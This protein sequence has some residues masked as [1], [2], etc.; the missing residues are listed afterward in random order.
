MFVQLLVTQVKKKP[1]EAL[2]SKGHSTRG[3]PAEN[4][5]ELPAQQFTALPLSR[6]WTQSE[7]ETNPWSSKTSIMSSKTTKKTPQN[8]VFQQQ[9]ST[10]H[11]YEIAS[12][13][14]VQGVTFL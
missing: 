1:L 12:I 14:V 6:L 8:N 10:H 7:A 2:Y 3:V 5:G 4:K 11:E 9:S 13:S